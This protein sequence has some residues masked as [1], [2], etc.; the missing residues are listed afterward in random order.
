V[1]EVRTRPSPLI[2]R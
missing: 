2:L 1:G